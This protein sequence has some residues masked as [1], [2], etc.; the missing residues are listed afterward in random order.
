MKTENNDW[1]ADAAKEIDEEYNAALADMRSYN[2]TNGEDPAPTNPNPLAIITHH[3]A[4]LLERAERLEK[5]LRASHK[6]T[7][8]LLAKLIQQNDYR[9]TKDQYLWPLIEEASAALTA[10]QAKE[11]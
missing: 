6:A 10:I 3:A 8:M 11:T 7:D 1:A 4:P 5:G 9:P 2:Q